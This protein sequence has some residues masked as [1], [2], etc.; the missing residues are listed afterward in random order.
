MSSR[1]ENKLLLD[2]ID[3]HFCIICI[4][5]CVPFESILLYVFEVCKAHFSAKKGN[6]SLKPSNYG[7]SFIKISMNLC[8]L[9]QLL[10]LPHRFFRYTISFVWRFNENSSF[11]V[12]ERRKN[13]NWRSIVNYYLEIFNFEM[14][15]LSSENTAV[16]ISMKPFTLWRVITNLKWLIIAIWNIIVTGHIRYA[17]ENHSFYSRKLLVLNVIARYVFACWFGP[18]FFSPLSK[19][20][21]NIVRFAK[22]NKMVFCVHAHERKYHKRNLNDNS[23]WYG[24]VDWWRCLTILVLLHKRFC[25]LQCSLFFCNFVVVVV[26]G[27]LFFYLSLL[28]RVKRATDHGFDAHNLAHWMCTMY[29]RT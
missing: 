8:K 12:V 18:N 14:G 3:Q 9:K 6:V 13:S 11:D 21:K 28:K 10:S 15:F 16:V 7:E 29:V 25:L 1:L 20:F 24:G 19:G 2:W 5:L 17:A 26:F 23:C 22:A 27:R 4:I